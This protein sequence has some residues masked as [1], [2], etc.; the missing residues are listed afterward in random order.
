MSEG[1]KVYTAQQAAALVLVIVAI[2]NMIYGA[3]LGGGPVAITLA[4][5]GFAMA[6]IVWKVKPKR[7]ADEI[8]QDD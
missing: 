4:F 8:A 1:T 2:F 6:I 3:Y 5:M 7:K